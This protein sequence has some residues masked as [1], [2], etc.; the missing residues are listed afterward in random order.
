MKKYFFSIV[1]IF[2]LFTA[3]SEGAISAFTEE[4]TLDFCTKKIAFMDKDYEASIK[5]INEIR[6]S[7]LAE[8]PAHA[9]DLEQEKCI[10]ESVY[11]MSVYELSL[12]SRGNTK[13]LR[14]QM[15]EIMKRNV[16]CLES[17][18]KNKLSDWLCL[19]TGDTT[20]FYMTRSV[21]ATFM[22]GFRVK[23]YYEKALEINPNR[24]F[25]RVN[26]GNWLFYAPFVAGGGKSRA[27]TQYNLALA[28]ALS[29]GEKYA[30]YIGVSQINYELGNTA[31]AEEYLQKAY[32]LSVGHS[33]LDKISRCNE[34]GYSNFQYLRNRSGIDVEMSEDEKDED[35]K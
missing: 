34:K 1:L 19:F 15:K 30:A 22:Y 27:Q 8:L 2:S 6:E 33:E 11:F 4:K 12:N 24:T 21:A 23:K 18:K 31:I 28:S 26:L 29:P 13:E 5:E 7:V 32:D 35:D 14:S 10:L 9:I 16:K 25:A 17:R 20:S 3:W